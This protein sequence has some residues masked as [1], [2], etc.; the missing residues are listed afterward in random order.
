MCENTLYHKHKLPGTHDYRKFALNLN[1]SICV[2]LLH[3]HIQ[4]AR[5]FIIVED[6]LIKGL[7]NAMCYVLCIVHCEDEKRL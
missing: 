4:K 5:V 6:I 2:V 7:L 3:F 1:S